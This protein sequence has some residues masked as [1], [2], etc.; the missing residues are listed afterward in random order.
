[1]NFFSSKV[2]LS[3]DFW[4]IYARWSPVIQSSKPATPASNA[5]V[6]EEAIAKPVETPQIQYKPSIP[7]VNA[8]QEQSKKNDQPIQKSQPPFQPN[9]TV[10]SSQIPIQNKPAASVTGS[11]TP[12]QVKPASQVQQSKPFGQ[13]NNPALVSTLGNSSNPKPIFFGPPT[14]AKS[15]PSVKPTFFGSQNRPDLQHSSSNTASLNSSHPSLPFLAF[16]SPEFKVSL[17]ALFYLYSI[18]QECGIWSC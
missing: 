6:S 8:Q 9:P 7:I 12:I 1:M 4:N 14:N 2:M 18:V 17:F 11:S 16:Y 3:V 10:G 5:Q 15:S 13:V